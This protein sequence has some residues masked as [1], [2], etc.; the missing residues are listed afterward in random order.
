MSITVAVI[1]GG[2]IGEAVARNL[3]SSGYDVIV[4]EKRVERV[5]DLKKTGLN[6]TM[7]NLA[8]ASRAEMVILCVKPKDVEGVL[9]EIREEIK[10]K[11]VVSLAAAITLDFLRKIAPEARF[12]RAMPNLAII[13]RESFIAYCLSPD[14][15]SE[16]LKK[17][18]GVLSALGSAN[19][20][21]ESHMDAITALSGCAP[22]YLSLIAEAMMY[23]G[24]EV[25]LERNLA[26]TLAAQAM[27]GTGKLIL[28]G[29]RVPSEIRDMVTTPGGVTIE[30]LFELE[31]FPI[32]HA[33]MSAV[34]AAAEKSRRITL[35][36]TEG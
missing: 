9:K 35:A 25:G 8:A 1:G 21:D 27:I 33:F 17:A 29:R 12:I 26:L 16:D 31:K 13:V 4:S 34:K 23:A 19:E 30:G 14:L 18:I 28:K 11:V 6:V 36:L 2:V 3:V 24:L 15:S 5:K 10:N 32:R 7:D 20:V 22:A